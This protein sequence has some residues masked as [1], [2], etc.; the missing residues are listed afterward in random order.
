VQLVLPDSFQRRCSAGQSPAVDVISRSGRLDAPT[1]VAHHST[2]INNNDS[3][4]LVADAAPWPFSPSRLISSPF[5]SL[6]MSLNAEPAALQERKAQHLPPKSYADAVDET[7]NRASD[8]QDQDLSAKDT[9]NGLL[10]PEPSAPE[11]RQAQGLPQK[12]YAEAAD[13]TDSTKGNKKKNIEHIKTNGVAKTPSPEEKD[14]YVGS[15]QDNSPKSPTRGTHR[16]KSS[17][18]SNGSVGGK[19]G[20]LLDNEL[21]TEVY[22]EHRSSNGNLL[23][24]V[25]PPKDVEKDTPKPNPPKRRNSTLKSGRQAGAGWRKSKYVDL[26]S[27]PPNRGLY[28]IHINYIFG[29]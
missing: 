5:L 6:D 22:E 7:S 23:T 24:S 19:T 1:L 16:R 9:T 26:I 12:S 20:E 10:N 8:T 3:P 25:K 14:Q 21:D 18:Q 29:L 28:H 11:D 15:G 17:K 27:C 2:N 13:E 4:D